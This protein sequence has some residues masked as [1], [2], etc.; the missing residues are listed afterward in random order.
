M[1]AALIKSHYLH[2]LYVAIA[3]LT[4]TVLSSTSDLAFDKRQTPVASP[5][6]DFQ[7]SQ[8]ILTPS[9]QGDQYGCIHTTLLMEY[10]FANSYGAPFVGT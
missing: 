4:S 6:V 3:L 2:C 10:E 8:P 1:S 5:L 9:G 7:V